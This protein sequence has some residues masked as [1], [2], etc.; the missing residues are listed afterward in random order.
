MM[1]NVID[2]FT[3][4]MVPVF[5]MWKENLLPSPVWVVVPIIATCYA[6]GQVNMKT[7]DAY[8]LGFPS[9]WNFIALYLFWLRPDPTITAILLLV[10]GILSFIPTRYLYPSKNKFLAKPSWALGILWAFLVLWLLFQDTPPHE[11]VL[12]SFFYPAYYMALSFYVDWRLRR[13]ER[14]AR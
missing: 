8:F 1:D 6:Y 2:V 9:Y 4:I 13:N 5:I 11:W 12:V 7:N 10:P 3:Y 14:R